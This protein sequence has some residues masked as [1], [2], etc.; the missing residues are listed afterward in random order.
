MKYTPTQREDVAKAYP[1]V[2]NSGQSGFDLKIPLTNKN[3]AGHDLQ[4][5]M[6]YSDDVNN[7]EGNYQDIWSQE[8]RF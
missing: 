4:V 6:R 2:Y 7:G 8:F 1:N 5:V 3:I